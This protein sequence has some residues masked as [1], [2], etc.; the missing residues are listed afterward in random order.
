MKT[1]PNKVTPAEVADELVGAY[2][3]YHERK[4]KLVEKSITYAES[5]TSKIFAPIFAV[6]L[7][8]YWTVAV[9][10]EQPPLGAIFDLS[11]FLAV[12]VMFYISHLAFFHL[13][14]LLFKPSAEEAADDTSFFALFSACPARE[15]RGLFSA[16]FGV[17]NAAFFVVY[18]IVKQTGLEAWRFF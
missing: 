6:L 16:A 8:G 4:E 18:L 3:T 12:V 14:K 5:G 15:R 11:G 1:G 10:W 9:L 13:S 7:L 17:G 2:R